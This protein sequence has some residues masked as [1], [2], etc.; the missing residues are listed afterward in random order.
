MNP[1]PEQPTLGEVL[2]AD[3]REF[4]IA[5]GMAA[6]GEVLERERTEAC[7]ARYAHLER[8]RCLRQ[9]QH[10]F[11]DSDRRGHDATDDQLRRQQER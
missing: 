6:L 10:L 1:A 5:A 7:G 8:E 2:R 11:P 3:L 4:V 9:Q